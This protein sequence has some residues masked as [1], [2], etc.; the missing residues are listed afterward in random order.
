MQDPRLTVRMLL[1]GSIVPLFDVFP[2]II[3]VLVDAAR[4]TA[5][6]RLHDYISPAT[7]TGL[8]I[9]FGESM[10][11]RTGPPFFEI[12]WLI[13][14]M[15]LILRYMIMKGVFKEAPVILDVDGVSVAAGFLTEK[16]AGLGFTNAKS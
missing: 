5:T 1:T 9:L 13:K 11:A 8:E 4:L 2:L 16:D 12:Q 7:T 14:S 6:S 15:P 3:T 10:P